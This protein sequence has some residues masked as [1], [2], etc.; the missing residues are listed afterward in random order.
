[1]KQLSLGILSA[2]LF[3]ATAVAQTPTPDCP[4]IALDFAGGNGIA[5][6][7]PNP[8]FDN[9]ST[10]CN[11]WTVAY[12]ADAGLSGYTVA[13][14][15]ATGSTTP[16]TFGAYTGNTVNSSASWG[17]AAVGLATYCGLATCTTGG[18]TVNTPWIRLRVTGASGTGNMHVVFYGYRTGYTGGSAR[19]G[20]GGGGGSGINQL[21]L[22]VLAG[23][24]TGSVPA[25]VV[26]ANGALIPLN[27]PEICTNAM[28]QIVTTGC[29]AAGGGAA[30]YTSVAFSAT[31]TFTASSNTDNSFSITL[32]GN[33]TSSI[34]ASS[35]SGQILNFKICQDAT[36]GRTFVW[37]T[38]FSKAPTISP[39]PSACTKQGFFWDG[40]I[41]QPVPPGSTDLGP[42][43]VGVIA[44]PGSNP[45]SGFTYSWIDSTDL[46]AE[47]LNSAGNNFAMFRTGV[48]A[49]PV[50]GQVTNLSHVT[51]SSLPNSGLVNTGTTV[52]GV[53]CVL[54]ASCTVTAAPS[55]TGTAND[56]VCYGAG[57]TNI[58][59]CSSLSGSVNVNRT[60]GTMPTIPTTDVAVIDA[61]TGRIFSG[62]FAN[63]GFFTSG[64]WDGTVGSPTA[65]Q[66]GEQL[67][68]YNSYAYNGTTF[69]GPFG[70][71]RCFANQIQAVGSGGTYCEVATTPNGSTTLTSVERWNADGGVTIPSTVTGGDKGIGT[72][73]A[74]GL[75]VNGTAVVTSLTGYVQGAGSLVTN[76]AVT[77]G[78]GSGSVLDCTSS[79]TMPGITYLGTTATNSASLGTE[80]TTSGTCSGTGWTGTFPN[81]TAPGTTASLTC[82]GFTSGSYYQTVT[83]IGAGGS[84]AVTVA[85]GTAQTAAASSGTLTAGL[86]ANGTSLTYTP[87]STYTGTIG[88]SAKLITPISTFTLTGKDSTGAVSFDA[89][90]QQTAGLH[91]TFLGGGG[92]Y[93]TTGSNN[94][95]NGYAALF[96]NTTGSNNVGN[97]YTALQANTTGSNNVGNGSVALYS[98]TGGGN[99]LANGT[100][101]LYSNTTGSGNVGNGY[102]AL[103]SNTG[104]GNNLASG[105]YAL[106]NN[107][108]GISNIGNGYA[109]LYANITGSGNTA[110]GYEAGYPAVTANANV[111]GSNNTYIGYQCGPNTATQLSNSTC[112]GNGALFGS[113]NEAVIGNA[114]VTDVYLGGEIAAAAVHHSTL[115]QNTAGTIVSGSTSGT[116]TF[117]ENFAGSAIKGVVIQCNAL[118]GTATFTLSPAFSQTPVVRTTSGL[119]SSLVTTL[120]TTTVTVTGATSTGPL[121]IDGY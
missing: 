116:A 32:T 30:Q 98:N 49:N 77:C 87:A 102:E 66:S 118:L 3:A 61:A 8:Y 91:N 88:I 106:Y 100:Y 5:P 43:Y 115:F 72:L 51:N 14:Q 90:L 83:S 112:L 68:G 33:V 48:D 109:T 84:G 34:L 92:T 2:L 19:G 31:P 70:S 73:N 12:E 111:S 108:T 75:F 104:G 50:T 89:L 99:N 54:G 22:D 114:S 64:R 120:T 107:T 23:P 40:S 47:L 18:T 21:T 80:L 35:A 20:G 13:F 15:S 81:Y 4:P 121:F 113:S 71:I 52:N 55:V 62:G 67:G 37:P 24:G 53:S 103:Y 65:V 7:L 11:S 26:G 45:N 44:A 97:G 42:A 59:D 10:Q 101:A 110:S 6:L 27:A 28:G 117:I 25:T 17:T 9:R 78:D 105:A 41:A 82:T 39:F 85:I 57:G 60:G 74:S 63:P 79:A 38:G 58:A 119:S 93:N 36:G 29:I 69:A 16:G 96:A 86:K 94:V 1:M 46:D 95:G 76:K 56:I